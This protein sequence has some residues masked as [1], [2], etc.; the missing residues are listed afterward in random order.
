VESRD[1]AVVLMTK[2][3][4]THM[5]REYMLKFLGIEKEPSKDLTGK[6]STLK[7]AKLKVTY[8]DIHSMP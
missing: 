3:I 7:D 6:F 8:R 1:V 5:S 2:R 4:I